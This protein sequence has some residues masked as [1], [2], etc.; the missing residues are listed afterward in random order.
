MKIYEDVKENGELI[1][2]DGNWDIYYFNEKCYAIAVDPQCLSSYYGDVRHVYKVLGDRLK[3]HREAG[4]FDYSKE[5]ALKIKKVTKRFQGYEAATDILL[6]SYYAGN[7]EVAY[8]MFDL[9]G[10]ELKP[11]YNEFCTFLKPKSWKDFIIFLLDKG[12]KLETSVKPGSRV[13]LTVS[14]FCGDDDLLEWLDKYG[15]TNAFVVDVSL[16]D[17]KIWIKGCPYAINLYDAHL[18]N[19]A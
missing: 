14:Q 18:I 5:I 19:A 7:I 16:Y 15:E 11:Y 3:R 9:E 4:Q 1:Y 6:R 13:N 10:I 8:E 17:Q 12:L 2:N